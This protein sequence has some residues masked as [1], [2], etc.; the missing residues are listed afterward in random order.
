M[1]LNQNTKFDLLLTDVIY[2]INILIK[3]VSD[4]FIVRI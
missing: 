4:V 2:G 3:I 1:I